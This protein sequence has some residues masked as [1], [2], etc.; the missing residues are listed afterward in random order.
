MSCKLNAELLQEL[1]EGT[2]DPVERIFVEE[3]LK[4]CHQCR[5]DL[6]EFKLLFWE[7]ED[8]FNF[9]VYIP[10]ELNQLK[11]VIF[12]K[13]DGLTPVSPSKM[14]MEQ[15]KSVVKKS[16]TFLDFV[17]GVKET[18]KILKNGA[19]ATPKALVKA[20]RSVIRGAKILL[21]R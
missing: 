1:L 16:S 20:S 21:A 2:I 11:N 15:Q 13:V 7:L 19:K 6:T 9:E 14:I 10:E 3:H 5:K 12:D 8:K 17:P 18:E 4:T